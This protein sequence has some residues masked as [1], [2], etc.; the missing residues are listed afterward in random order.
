MLF[1]DRQLDLHQESRVGI[2]GGDLALV[3]LDRPGRDCQTK[4]DAA[5]RAAAVRFDAVERLEYLGKRIRGHAWTEVAERDRWRG[6]RGSTA[7]PRLHFPSGAWR[8][9]LRSTLS[10]ARCR[11]SKSPVTTAVASIRGSKRQPCISASSAQLVTSSRSKITDVD[12]FEDSGGRVALRTSE[13]QQLVDQV[14]EP[15]G[16]LAN[17]GERR[18]AVSVGFGELDGEPQPRQ[19]RS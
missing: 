16:F 6:G 10:Q 18:L 4:A 12:V 17:A 15:V 2:P 8:M 14:R 7:E 13:L 3:Q 1:L 11:S 9:A 5:A 19:R